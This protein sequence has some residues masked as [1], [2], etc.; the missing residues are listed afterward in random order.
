MGD[1]V[2]KPDAEWQRQLNSAS[3]RLMLQ[4]QDQG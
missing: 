3:L 2:V 1:K 4:K